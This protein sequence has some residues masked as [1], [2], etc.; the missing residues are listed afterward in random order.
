MDGRADVAADRGG[1]A[2]IVAVENLFDANLQT[3]RSAA[4]VV[5]YDAP[6]RVQVGLNLRL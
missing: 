4:D 3:G 6:R 1:S 2:S 5:T